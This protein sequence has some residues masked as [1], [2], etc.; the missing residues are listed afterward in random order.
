MTKFYKQKGRDVAVSKRRCKWCREYFDEWVTYPA[1]TF[2]TL[3]HALE[4]ARQPKQVAKAERKVHRER[5]R[6]LRD[7]DRGYWLKKA[8]AAFNAY[9]RSR[10]KSD[11]CISC[12][13]HHEGQYHAGHYRTVG[14]CPELRF[15]PLNC[16]KQCAPCNNHLSGNLVLYRQNLLVKIGQEKL[17]WLEGSHEPKRYSI[18]DLKAIESEYKEKLKAIE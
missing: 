14:S 17:D 1:G 13:R 8:Q 9:I 10:D 3:E 7:N 5:V 12:Q 18:D 15:D 4:Y 2:C 16:H 11:P 6:K